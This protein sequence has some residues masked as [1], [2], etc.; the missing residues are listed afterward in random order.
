MNT[1]KRVS[2]TALK[3]FVCATYE[4]AGMP[5]LDAELVADSLVQADL[6][7]HQSHGVLR[8]RWYLE[9]LRS[10]AM[11]ATTEAKSVID[12]G[13]FAV[14]DGKDGVGHVVARNAM[15]S[16]IERASPSRSGKSDAFVMF[17]LYNERMAS[18]RKFDGNTILRSSSSLQ[19]Y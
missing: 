15:F 14:M 11:R 7:G 19:V 5:F 10:G 13:A 9:R 6:W 16:A 8:T 12:G 1:S 17:I 2:A 18:S 3:R 4:T